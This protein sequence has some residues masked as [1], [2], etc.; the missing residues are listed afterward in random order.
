MKIKDAENQLLAPV[1]KIF[2]AR[3]YIFKTEVPF[4]KKSIDV[5]IGNT[6]TK[7]IT[8]IELK[9][10]N[11]NKAL[12]Q[13]VVYQLCSHKVYVAI[14]KKYFNPKNAKS[15]AQFG[16]G[17]I[18]IDLEKRKLKGKIFLEAK[19]SKAINRFYL[20]GFMKIYFGKNKNAYKS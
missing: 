11:W 4:H 3:K 15:F 10:K 5:M 14:F 12:R 20:E 17:I 18:L 19:R 6:Q 16:V 8:A 9:V 13:A 7:E 2:G 1:K